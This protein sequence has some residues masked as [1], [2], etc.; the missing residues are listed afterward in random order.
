MPY[1]ISYINYQNGQANIGSRTVDKLKHY[2]ELVDEVCPV[3][4]AVILAICR[5][6]KKEKKQ[7]STREAK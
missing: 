7:L 6:T 4:G 5:L 2:E 3:K 1:L